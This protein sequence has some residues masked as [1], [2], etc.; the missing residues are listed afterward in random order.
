MVKLFRISKLVKLGCVIVLGLCMP[1]KLVYAQYPV[2]FSGY[3]SEMPSF[4]W[5]EGSQSSTFDVLIHNRINLEHQINDNFKAKIDFRNRLFWGDMVESTVN[6]K[7]L[8]SEDDGVLDMSFNWE[9]HSKYLLNT[10]IDRFSLEY[11]KEN[12]Q[13]KVGRQRVN[14]SQTMVWNPND[15]FNSYSYLDFD[16]S[17]RPGMDGV[18]M[19]YFTGNTSNIE[20]VFKIDKDLDMTFASLYRFNTRGYDF[21]FIAGEL[22]QED[23][24]IGGGWSGS[25]CGAGFYGELSY[26]SEMDNVSNDVFVSSIGGNYIFRNS[27]L[28]SGEYLYSSNLANYEGSYSD[29]LY[30]QSSVKRMSITDH[31]YV[32]SLFYPITPSL[33]ISVA[34]MGLGFPMAKSFYLGPTANYSFSDNLYL[35]GVLQYYNLTEYEG[36]VASYLRLKWSF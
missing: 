30:N 2:D 5:S 3:L 24:I 11:E 21:Q 27:L 22:E 1:N 35:T 31:S 14:W 28:L 8:A 29:L 16:Y 10:T 33:N 19:Q 25:I 36:V 4:I 26:F 23:F 15:I 17:E 6:F 18:R 13:L 7:Y 20:A 34:Y 9:S 12:I 32:V